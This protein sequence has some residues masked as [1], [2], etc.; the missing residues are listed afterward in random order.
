M[1]KELIGTVVSLKMANT[2]VVS[3]MR[4]TRHPIY[5]KIVRKTKRYKAHVETIKLKLGDTVMI[6]ETRPIS[7]DKHFKVVSIVTK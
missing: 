5:K 6:R 7:R 4:N 3:V 2:A 1:A